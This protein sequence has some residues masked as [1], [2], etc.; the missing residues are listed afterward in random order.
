MEHSASSEPRDGS[1]ARRAKPTCSVSVSCTYVLQYWLLSALSHTRTHTH[2]HVCTHIGTQACCTKASILWAEYPRPLAQSP[3]HSRCSTNVC[4]FQ[5]GCL[6]HD[7]SPVQ[8]PSD[9]LDPASSG[10]L[11]GLS[12]S[13]TREPD[14]PLAR[15]S[16]PVPPTPSPSGVPQGLTETCEI[17]RDLGL[18]APL[19]I[20]EP[21]HPRPTAHLSPH[22][23]K[24][25]QFLNTPSLGFVHAV[26]SAWRALPAPGQSAFDLKT[27]CGCHLL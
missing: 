12:P 16:H 20:P 14:E 11:T 15:T 26:P 22:P 27:L 3:A 18:T 6:F 10:T 19:H 5:Q 1:T 21:L 13:S 9:S 25:S 7:P 24:G 2:T 8:M 17:L 4:R 23:I